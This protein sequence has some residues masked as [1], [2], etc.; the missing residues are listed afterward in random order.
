[1]VE[2]DTAQAH[3]VAIFEPECYL[4]QLGHFFELVSLELRLSRPLEADLVVMN[5]CDTPQR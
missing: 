3:S 2:L 5:V 1:M 4:L